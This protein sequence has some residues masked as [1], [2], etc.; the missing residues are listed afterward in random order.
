MSKVDSSW[1]TCDLEK[2]VRVFFLR[3]FMLFCPFGD[4]LFVDLLSESLRLSKSS[5]SSISPS[6][7]TI[8]SS[9]LWLR[10]EEDPKFW[11]W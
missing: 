11:V 3:L 1:K 8:I 2:T 7:S 4:M 9:L 10:F 5:L 6:D